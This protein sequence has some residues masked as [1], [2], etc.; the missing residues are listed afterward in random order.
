M[1]TYI[2]DWLLLREIILAPIY[3]K[4]SSRDLRLFILILK[5]EEI[6]EALFFPFDSIFFFQD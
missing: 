2:V 5:I 1:F 3:T 4:I 6:I